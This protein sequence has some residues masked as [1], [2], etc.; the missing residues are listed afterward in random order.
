MDNGTILFA[1]LIIATA[2]GITF[3]IS[4]VQHRKKQQAEY[5]ELW[6]EFEQSVTSEDY[7]QMVEL[8]TKVIYNKFVRTKH[9]EKIQAIAKDLELDYPEF[10]K[11]RLN[12]YDKWI[13][14]TK[15]RG[16]G[17]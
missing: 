11:L 16:H 15:G 14:H 9:L 6:K 2:L 3:R 13:H 5:P 12:A 8:G 4:L 10:E 1:T 7:S 17:Y